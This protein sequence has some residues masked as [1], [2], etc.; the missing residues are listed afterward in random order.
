MTSVVFARTAF[1]S[2]VVILA[3]SNGVC[4]QATLELSERQNQELV[5]RLS[6]KVER[7]NNSLG[8]ALTKPPLAKS[9]SALEFT[10]YLEDFTLLI[11]DLA[12]NVK[13]RYDIS[14]VLRT[15][16]AIERLLLCEDVPA[17]VVVDW[18][19]L[20]ADLDLLAR[21]YGLKWS[22]AVVTNELIARFAKEVRSF[23]DSLN[24][25]LPSV[26]IVR[27]AE[28]NELPALMQ[29]FRQAAQSLDPD[30]R[31]TQHQI[32]ILSSSTRTLGLYL[33]DCS[34]GLQLQTDWRR[35]SAQVEEFVRI[36]NLDFGEKQSP[37]KELFT[38]RK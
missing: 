13:T 28:S 18:S 2:V 15:A 17:R 4:A 8:K 26:Q 5:K 33:K 20:H 19:S 11:D 12:L 32:T 16:S 30:S 31:T 6:L 7:F 29:Q 27:T 37:G 14:E 3:L 35:L 1:L 24:I 21:V 36:Y 10:E 38:K 22:E 23:S 9:N 34:L 25:D